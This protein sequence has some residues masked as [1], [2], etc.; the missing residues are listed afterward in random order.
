MPDKFEM[1]L[2]KSIY[3]F[4]DK[5]IKEIINDAPKNHRKE[6]MYKQLNLLILVKAV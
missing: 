5:H 3:R 4:V 2:K 6:V 1:A